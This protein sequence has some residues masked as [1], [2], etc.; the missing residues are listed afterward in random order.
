[1]AHESDLRERVKR[2]IV[3]RLRLDLKPEEI[4]D[5]APLFSEGLALDSVDVLELVVGFE[6]EFGIAIE[7]AEEGRRIFQSIDSMVEYLERNAPP[8]VGTAGHG[9]D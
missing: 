3:D 1:M 6:K 5:G 4:D 7:D 2:M 8:G 9:E